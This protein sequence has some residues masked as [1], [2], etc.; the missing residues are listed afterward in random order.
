MSDFIG[1]VLV[2][3]LAIALMLW[4]AHR[5]IRNLRKRQANHPAAPEACRQRG[6]G[7]VVCADCGSAYVG[8]ETVRAKGD[9][10]GP[11]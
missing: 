5:D 10:D 2:F 4:A 9:D 1:L 11:T 8:V 3:L 6:H 7:R